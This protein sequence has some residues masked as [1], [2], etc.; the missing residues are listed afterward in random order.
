LDKTPVV[1]SNIVY[2][3][4]VSTTTTCHAFLGLLGFSLFIGRYVLLSMRPAWKISKIFLS[5]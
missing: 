3:G 4:R 5:P 2:V 1:I